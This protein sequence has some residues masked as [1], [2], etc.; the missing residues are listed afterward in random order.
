MKERGSL[1]GQEI[2]LGKKKKGVIKTFEEEKEVEK[3]IKKLP[4]YIVEVENPWGVDEVDV[5]V[6]A[7]KKEGKRKSN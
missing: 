3:G 6:V 1:I 5:P 4:H 2:N 7:I